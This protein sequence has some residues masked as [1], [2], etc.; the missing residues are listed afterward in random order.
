M[1]KIPKGSSGGNS[2]LCRLVNHEETY[3]SH[4]IESFFNKISS[5]KIVT[6]IIDLGAGE[7]RDLSASNKYFNNAKKYGIE[8][9]G[10]YS[11]KNNLY[12][13]ISM[14]IEN[15]KI[16]FENEKI[17]IIIANQVLEHTKELFWIMHE[18]SRT[19]EIGGDLIIGVPNVLSFHNRLLM[20]FGVH[21]TQYKSYSAHVRPFSKNDFLNFINICFPN[22][23]FLQYFKGSQFYPFPPLISKFMCSV[24][25]NA[26]FSIFFLLKKIK[27][28]N[29]Q[30]LDY[31]DTEKLETPFFKG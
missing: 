25:P 10:H 18:I 20:L 6:K 1:K 30:F 17:S 16:P 11:H 2:S 22:G 9:P 8:T 15:Q 26:S 28:Y 14:N 27:K 21:P 23:Y 12:N 31:L 7:G 4:V 13:S 19:L 3:G 5:E 29:N 24:F